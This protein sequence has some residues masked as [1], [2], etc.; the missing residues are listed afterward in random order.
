MRWSGLFSLVG[1]ALIATS[2]LAHQQK[3]AIT[4]VLF[5]PRT[6]NIEV[7]HRFYIHD[8]EHAVKQILGKEA[9]ILTSTATQQAFAD[10]VAQRFNIS[11]LD[12]QR[13]A[14]TPVGFEVEGQFFWVY[15][16]TAQIADLAGLKIQHSAL[17]DIWNQQTNT[18]NIEGLGEVKTLTF[19]QHVTLLEVT[20]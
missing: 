5:N 13:L 17:R 18:V 19:E 20:F 14:L 7:I 3:T 6:S 1:V 8:A 2:A 10:Y 9:D 11:D 4:K 15:Q 12:N 16:E